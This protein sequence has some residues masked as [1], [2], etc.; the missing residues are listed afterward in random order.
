VGDQLT[1]RLLDGEAVASV[2]AV[3]PGQPTTVGSEV[4]A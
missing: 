3:A 4:P 1:A 2:T